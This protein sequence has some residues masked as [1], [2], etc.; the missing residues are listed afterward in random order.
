MGDLRYTSLFVN[1]FVV[2]IFSIIGL[3]HYILRYKHI[4]EYT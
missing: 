3:Y 4:I 1:K 2:A